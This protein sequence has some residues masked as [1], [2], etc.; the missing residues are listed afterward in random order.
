MSAIPNRRPQSE[1]V[2]RILDITPAMAKQYLADMHT[3]RAYKQRQ[4][5]SFVAAMR[6][7]E[8]RLNGQPILISEAG[9]LMDGQHRMM[10]VVQSGETVRFLVVQGV[11][12]AAMVTVDRGSKRSFADLLSMDGY[13]QHKTLAAAIR[14]AMTLEAGDFMNHNR[15]P[16]Y[17]SMSEW[18][19]INPRI[20]DCVSRY[21]QKEVQRLLP[22]N[23][24]AAL[25]Y[26]MARKDA[27]VAHDFWDKVVHGD[28]LSKTDA[29]FK[30]RERLLAGVRGVGHHT[31]MKERCAFAIKAWNFKR[32]GQDFD[33]LLWKYEGEFPEPF[34]VIS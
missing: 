30:L 20:L 7:G 12:E 16:S 31:M 6:N 13:K 23:M 26:L 32:R 5:D 8:W 18:F 27:K 9:R 1:L 14:T 10:A 24:I 22:H 11:P 21:K 25:L 17:E 2:S 28:G 4:V 19:K 34:P 33:R 15:L 3:N 29:E